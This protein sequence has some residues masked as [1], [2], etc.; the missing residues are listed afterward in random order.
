MV[1]KHSDFVHLHVHTQYSLL[2]GMI[3]VKDLVRRAEEFRMP[4]VAI[5]DH[6]QMYGIV[7]FYSRA[8]KAGVKP[9][10]GCE[11]YV[12]PGDMREK[13][14][15]IGDAATHLT[16]LARNSKG[17]QN[18]V[19]LTSAANLVGFYYRP[20]IDKEFLSRH[21]EG[22]IA[23]SGCLKGEI[24][25]AL[26]GSDP[27]K[28]LEAAETYRDIFGDGNF[29]LE[30]QSNG[31]EE[32]DRANA[33]MVELS[34]ETGIPVVATNDC[35]YL[36]REDAEIHEALLCLQTGKTLQDADRMRLSTDQFYF[37]S[38]EEMKEIFADTP[39]AIRSTIEIAE[40]CNVE[41]DLGKFYFPRFVVPEEETLKSYLRRLSA[42]GLARR[43]GHLVGE[44]KERYRKRLHLELDVIEKMRPRH[45]RHRPHSLRPALREVPQPRPHEPAR[46]RY[47]F[48]HGPPRRGHRLRPQEVR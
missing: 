18:L 30:L 5:S 17:Y 2:D 47:R 42:D 8:S 20:R 39:E 21:A 11:L 9:I 33:A 43:C 28:A 3:F 24:P 1:T 34:R 4:A 15:G 10:L 41:L 26:L 31:I 7:D 40:R 19:E 22:L 6:G 35:H 45:H 44:E 16:L 14:G 23:L 37:R 36:N 25:R 27:K 32:Q 12:A 29:Y 13:T 48:R 38:P 46:Y